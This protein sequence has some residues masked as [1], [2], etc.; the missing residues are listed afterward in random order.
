MTR[1]IAFAVGDTAGHVKPA[2]A[3]AEAFEALDGRTE[4]CLFAAHGDSGRHFAESAG[5]TV[6]TL[7]GAP[8][9]RVGLWTRAAAIPR[10]VDAFRRARP[11]L[12]R[13]GMRLV[14]GTGGYASGAV[15]L[16]GRSLG[17]P[18]A[19]VEPN[20]VPGLANRLLRGWVDR[21]YV[22][23]PSCARYFGRR[24]VVTGT[25]LAPAFVAKFEGRHA[26][27][28]T[29]G[30]FRVLVMGASRGEHFLGEHVPG[31]LA[32]AQRRGIRLEV[33]HQAGTLDVAGLRAEYVRLGVEATV[34]PFLADV[35]EAYGWAH[36]VV[37]RAGANTVAELAVAALPALLI[38]L[39]DA[40]LGHQDVNAAEYAAQGAALWCR[41]HE[42]D[43]ES[44]ADRIGTLAL[45]RE[46]WSAM[47]AAALTVARP[48]AARAVV[49]DCE[50]L[51]GNRW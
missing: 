19:L 29:Q 15:V 17:L 21:A 41:E 23:S 40:A 20:A 50:Q 35:A 27:P 1:R 3:I 4:V 22:S 10:A 13:A 33:H 46:A 2:L 44:L 25:P 34:T 12:R 32:R 31:L 42:F 16:A 14:I 49:H 9:V 6:V 7:P 47:S 37:G 28:P 5:R 18:T 51:M 45:D 36:F 39:A 8:L 26:L 24:S 30:S 11:L 43:V 38:P 48:Y